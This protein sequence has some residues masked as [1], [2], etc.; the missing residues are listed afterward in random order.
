[1]PKKKKLDLKKERAEAEAKR[2]HRD[3]LQPFVVEF[4]STPTCTEMKK[5]H[6]DNGL[7]GSEASR[8]LLPFALSYAEDRLGGKSVEEAEQAIVAKVEEATNG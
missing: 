7:K 3:A 1:M 5:A 8:E 4:L 2:A 6:M